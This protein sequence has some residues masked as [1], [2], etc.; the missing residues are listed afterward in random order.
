M[1]KTSARVELRGWGFNLLAY[2]SD[3]LAI[4]NF[5]PSGVASTPSSLAVSQ[6]IGHYGQ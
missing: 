4:V 5:T 1:H 6:A 3:P 2:S